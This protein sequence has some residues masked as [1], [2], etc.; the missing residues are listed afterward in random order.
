MKRI[1]WLSAV[2]LLA[3]PAWGA[4]TLSVQQLAD[5]LRAMQQDKKSDTE[6]AT[7][8][9][10]IV[11]SQELT[12]STMNGLVSYVPG[13][14]STEQI[15]VLEARSAN[16]APPESDLPAR[17]A[18]AAAEQKSILDKAATYVTG[19]YDRLPGLVA[20]KTT[21][22]FQDNVEAVAGSSGVRGG[23]T[24]VVIGQ[25]FSN[26]ATFV[27]YINSSA[28]EVLSEHGAEKTPAEKDRT[29]WGANKMI[30]LEDADPALGTVF[31]EAQASEST[32]WLRWEL[33]NGK[34]AAVFSFTVPRKK[35]HLDVDVCCFP[36][37]NQAGIATFYTATTAA[38]L[39][40]G[41]GG[42]GGGV[43]GNFQTN[44]EWHSYK[45]SV[46]Y[47][48]EIF[49]DPE[50]GMVMRL[51]IFEEFKPSE[52]VHRIDERIDYGPVK[53]GAE[54]L[55]APIKS[56]INTEVV[57]NGDSGAA[58]Y[59]TRCTLFTSEYKDYRPAG[60]N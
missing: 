57:P 14:M 2:V 23:A 25:G 48:G 43:A 21:L 15:Y 60:A 9:K 24:D 19:T 37:I 36:K 5:M 28:S 29:P 30:A 55:I 17:P 51:I 35:A 22:R 1:G 53:T 47:H 59:T 31:R 39:G 3:L 46:P 4:R 12:R 38:T 16:L 54:T 26:P 27:H 13:P 56:Y 32:K 34:I 50:T 6:I 41:G 33:L 10:Q 49:V 8:L 40:D 42:G 44:T 18:P 45:A 7:A 52:V 11:L 20:T 58:S